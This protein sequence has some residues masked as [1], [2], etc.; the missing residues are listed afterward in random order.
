MLN[1]VFDTYK[2][3]IT[4]YCHPVQQITATDNTEYNFAFGDS[5]GGLT[6]TNIPQQFTVDATVE[7]MDLERD[8]KYEY[9]LDSAKL[10]D[11]LGLIRVSID[12]AADVHMKTAEKIE[13]LGVGYE[14]KSGPIKRGLFGIYQMDYY[15]GRIDTTNG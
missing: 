7:Y 11:A 4:I 1:E 10:K 3:Q 15:L 8:E 6:Y 12:V 14:I 13:V 2:T 5:T 9:P